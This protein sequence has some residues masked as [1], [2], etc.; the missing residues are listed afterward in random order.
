[1]D[2]EAEKGSS[3]VVFEKKA[4]GVVGAQQKKFRTSTEKGV[5]GGRLY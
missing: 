5:S 3:A 4:F 1:M 2:Q